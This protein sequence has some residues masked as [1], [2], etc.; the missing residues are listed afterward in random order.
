M[1]EDF[2]LLCTPNSFDLL[3]E[4]YFFIVHLI[5]VRSRGRV[6]KGERDECKHPMTLTS[7]LW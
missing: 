2:D 1:K 7:R 4:I 3:I 6:R 5:C